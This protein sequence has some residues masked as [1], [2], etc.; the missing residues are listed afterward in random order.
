MQT[1]R[2]YVVVTPSPDHNP[3]PRS[4]VVEATSPEEAILEIAATGN[5]GPYTIAD[6]RDLAGYRLQST[7]TLT[8]PA[9]MTTSDCPICQRPLTG[10][11]RHLIPGQATSAAHQGCAENWAADSSVDHDLET[12]P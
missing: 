12:R 1:T 9:T 10:P 7:V 3:T 11:T 4:M 5:P 2:W 8:R 6:I